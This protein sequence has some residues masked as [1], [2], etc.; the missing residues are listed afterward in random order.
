MDITFAEVVLRTLH[1]TGT[2]L[3]LACLAGIPLGMVVGLTQFPG[4]RLVQVFLYTGMGLPPV[5][6]GLV[7]FLL[8]SNS[9]P[10]GFLDWLFTPTGMI[11]AQTILAFPLAAGLTAASV[12][13][14]PADLR[15]QIR[16]L[17]ATPWQERWTILREARSGVLAAI[18]AALGRVISEV[19][20]AMLVGGNIAGSTRVLS[21]AIVL[22]TRQGE[23]GFALALGMVLLGIALLSNTLALRLGGRWVS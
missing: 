20:A 8:L 15:M 3:L 2:A 12:G 10:L 4:R 9:G 21:T 13:D 11:L 7:V 19:G 5:V 22:E 18:L 17:G 14:V 6:V 1:V 16:S 23:F